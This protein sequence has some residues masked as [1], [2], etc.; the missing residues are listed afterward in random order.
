MN[1]Q[2]TYQTCIARIDELHQQGA[3]SRLAAQTARGRPRAPSR[4]RWFAKRGPRPSMT[5]RFA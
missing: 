4:R 3:S 5:G 2:I 1:P